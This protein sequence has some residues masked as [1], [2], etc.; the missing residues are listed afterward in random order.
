MVGVQ[1]SIGVV[2]IVLQECC[3]WFYWG[4]PQ[5]SIPVINGVLQRLFTM[6][7]IGD[8]HVVQG[9]STRFHWGVAQSS[10]DVVLWAIVCMHH[11]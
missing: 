10:R 7:Y 3:I 2:Y 4:S 11:M 5:D 6:F 8:V 9:W 1:R